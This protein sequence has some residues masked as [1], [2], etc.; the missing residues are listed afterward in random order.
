MRE[1]PDGELRLNYSVSGILSPPTSFAKRGRQRAVRS[2]EK[3]R[4]MGA[5]QMIGRQQLPLRPT[6]NTTRGSNQRGNTWV[7]ETSPN[8]IS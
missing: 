2:A 8:Q 3:D 5:A 4:G 7:H 6:K 1:Y